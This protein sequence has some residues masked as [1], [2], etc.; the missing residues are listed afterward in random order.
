MRARIATPGTYK[1]ARCG[2]RIPAEFAPVN[3]ASKSGS[4]LTV[5]PGVGGTGLSLWNKDRWHTAN[6]PIWCGNIT[7]GRGP[8]DW[9]AR[10][11]RLCDKLHDFMIEWS[12][13]GESGVT[14]GPVVEAYMEMPKFFSDK[15]AGTMV[16]ETGD[17]IK[18][19]YISGAIGQVIHNHEVILHHIRVDQWKGQLG[20]P[21]VIERIKKR[22]P[23]IVQE[24][25]PKSHSW[26]SIGLGLWAKGRFTLHAGSNI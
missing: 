16:A 13:W 24:L 9:L 7:P 23:G 17:L 21:I 4:I 22:L 2:P 19:A 20:K 1:P 12:L 3:P 18:L 26:D 8:Q 15:A 6:G 25:N 14:Y 5:D 11:D 10:V